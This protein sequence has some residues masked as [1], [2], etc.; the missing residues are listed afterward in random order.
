VNNWYII[1]TKDDCKWC[2]KAK[3]LLQV[4]GIDYYEKDLSNPKYFEE[5]KALGVKTVP[6]VMKEETLIG[7]YEKLER[8]LNVR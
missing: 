8:H 4:M 5:W 2:V 1:Y 3:E 6:Q 7:G